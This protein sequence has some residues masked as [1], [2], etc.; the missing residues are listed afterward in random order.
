MRFLLAMVFTASVFLMSNDSTLKL[1]GVHLSSLT[2]LLM[3]GFFSIEG[4]VRGEFVL[5][6][7]PLQFPLFLLFAWAALSLL[8][9]LM[10]PSKMVPEAAY[11]YA[12]A[13]GVNG[14]SVRGLA[15]LIRLFLSVFAIEFLISSIDTPKRYFTVFNT[16]IIFYALACLFGVTQVFFHFALGVDI[17]NVVTYPNFR[18]GG[19][20]GEPQTFGIL[21]V[22]GLFPVIA[23]IK[24]EFEWVWFKRRTLKALLFI[25]LI[26]LVFTFSVSMLVAVVVTLFVF[27]GE[28]RKRTLLIYAIAAAALVVVFYS[29]VHAILMNKLMS[30]ALTV[31]SRT[32]TWAIGYSAMM[33]HYIAGV[34]IGQ[35]PLFSESISNSMN[36]SFVS[37]DFYSVRVNTLNTY[38]EW[39]AETG[40]AGLLII[41]WIAVRAW[42]TGRARGKSEE[43]R[44]VKFAF[45]GS[46]VALC[47]S[48]NSY[49]GAFYLGCV[50]LALAMYV[51]GM[52]LFNRS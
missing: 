15:F 39:G 49:G 36:L 22:S 6:K 24:G 17:G 46:L 23:A 2:G 34:G 32:L 30:E 25:A 52:M 47:V 9:S 45:G 40:A 31:N 38:L 12:W 11:G 4:L 20:V 8:F 28:I 41:A 48:A 16:L 1:S 51:S 13:R 7:H 42:R 19:Y 18:I 10:A 50:A 26:S 44:L 5:K 37:L 35:L 27:S 21:I 14:P 33:E 29:S 43:Y 3:F